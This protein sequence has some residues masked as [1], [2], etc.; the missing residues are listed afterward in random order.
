VK[1]VNLIPKELRGAGG[2][3]RTGAGVYV[4]LGALAVVVVLVSAWTLASRTVT[5]KQNDLAK[6]KVEADAAEVR[7]NQLAPY[8]QF[9]DL[10]KKRVETVT[11]LSRSRF[12]W[13]YALREVSR[14]LPAESWLTG[15]VGTV[16]PGVP[17]EDG[18]TGN[19]G[20]LRSQLAVPAIEA[21]GCSTSQKAVARYLAELRRIDGVTRVSLAS[22][23]KSDS[24]GSTVAA[25][26]DKGG[27]ATG[28]TGS[29]CRR[30]NSKIPKFDLVVFFERST[31]TASG[32]T[33]AVA[34]PAPAPAAG[35]GTTKEA[36]K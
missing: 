3:G 27:G 26:T 9:A 1:A 35:N 33:G 7:A 18:G 19:T 21:T 6:V 24:N 8:T 32:A 16:A 34:A 22:S 30:G 23:E 13:P 10:R 12:N 28:P 5:N 31:A 4:L 20:S 29:D 2:P 11:S 25:P 15:V 17:V 36:G 14:V